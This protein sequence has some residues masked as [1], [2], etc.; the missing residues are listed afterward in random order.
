M[1]IGR[2]LGRRNAEARRSAPALAGIWAS[3]DAGSAQS[4]M[5]RAETVGLDRRGVLERI[6]TISLNCNTGY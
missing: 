1:T 6:E 2:A 4:E 5:H 3:L